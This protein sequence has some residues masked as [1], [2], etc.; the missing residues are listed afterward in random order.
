MKRAGFT[1][2]PCSCRTRAAS[3]CTASLPPLSPMA[4]DPDSVSLTDL[5]PTLRWKLCLGLQQTH[6]SFSRASSCQLFNNVFQPLT[7]EKSQLPYTQFRRCLLFKVLMQRPDK[8]GHRPP[9]LV[10]QQS[11]HLKTK[12]HKHSPALRDGTVPAPVTW[13]LPGYLEMGVSELSL[14]LLWMS[15]L[16]SFVFEAKVSHS[17]NKIGSLCYWIYDSSYAW[18]G[19]AFYFC[20][21]V[22]GQF[23]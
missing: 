10:N 16:F 5:L 12:K 13:N 6:H 23:R 19:I 4:S 22:L 1:P 21:P 11:E 18:L 2:T 9:Q 15:C 7:P 20:V 3:S 8:R 17:T 14:H